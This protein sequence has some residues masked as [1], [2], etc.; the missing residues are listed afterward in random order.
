MGFLTRPDPPKPRA[1]V[2]ALLRRHQGGDDSALAELLDSTYQE[3]RL[4]AQRAFG[5]EFDPAHTLQPTALLHEAWMRLG[6]SLDQVESRPHFFALAARAMRRVLTDHARARLTAKR[7]A[8]QRPGA[9]DEEQAA[10]VP[11]DLVSLDDA[12]SELAEL[13]ARHARVVELRVFGG[14][15]IAETASELGVSTATVQT[16]WATAR[17]WLRTQLAS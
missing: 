15:T 17:A 11:A 13:D 5:S 10:Y 6:G 16:D 4:V 2:T 8:G 14:L 9:L 7:G 12:L 3:L 1:D